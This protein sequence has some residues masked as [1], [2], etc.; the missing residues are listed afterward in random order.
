MQSFIAV[1][2][3][4]RCILLCSAQQLVEGA[5]AAGVEAN[6]PHTRATFPELNVASPNI[7]RAE[8]NN[9]SPTNE[10]ELLATRLEAGGV[11]DPEGMSTALAGLGL[12]TPADPGSCSTTGRLPNLTKN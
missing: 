3:V 8:E 6:H 2:A 1:A 7:A 5:S 9:N 11:H 4:A 12:R 10:A